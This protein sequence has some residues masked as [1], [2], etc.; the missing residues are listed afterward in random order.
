MAETIDHSVDP[1]VVRAV[2]ESVNYTMYA[3]FREA[4]LAGNPPAQSP[5]ESVDELLARIDGIEN[6]T[7]RGWYDISGFRADADVLVWW[8]APTTE[9]LQAAYRALVDWSK[10]A[11]LPVWSNIAVHRVAEFNTSHV[12]GFL[13]GQSPRDYVCVYPFVRSRDW[14]VLPEEDRK[15]MLREHGLAAR[16]YADVVANTAASFALGDYE[17]LLAFEADELYRI[18]DL[19]RE[20]R[21]VDARRHVLEETPFFTGPRVSP[22]KVLSRA[23]A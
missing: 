21:A 15:R 22:E 2:N 5:A 11:L 12:P 1:D 7:T 8:H 6:L 19:M 23:I 16:D 4:R 14:Y 9:A 10:G 18:T 17:W 13:A 20:L 3:V